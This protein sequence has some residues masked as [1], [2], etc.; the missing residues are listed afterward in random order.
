MGRDLCHASR[1]GQNAGSTI[2][3]EAGGKPMRNP[4][5]ALVAL[6]LVAAA[7]VPDAHAPAFDVASVKPKVDPGMTPMICLV[8]CSPGERLTVEGAR[9]DIRYMSL[10][11]LLLTA[12][13]LKPYQLSGPDW[14][15][16]Q[17]FDILAKIPEGGSKDKVPEMLQSLLAE[18][19]KLAVHRENK[20]Q[21]VYAL[22]VG[23]NGQ[24]L[25]A[26]AADADAPLPNTPGARGLYT[27]GGEASVDAN[28]NVAI[29]GGALG[30]MRGGRGS[31]GGMKMD[32]LKIT[33]S[34]LADLLT[35][36]EDRP[37]VDM[38][39]L[40]GAYRFTFVIVA[41]SG[42]SGR[43]G[44]PPADG[45]GGRDGG[46][47]PPRDI[48]GDALFQAL[49]RAGLKLEKSKAPVATIVVDHLEKT[50][51]EN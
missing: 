1:S 18:R 26:P 38:T 47:D 22:V 45:A 27:P 46:A 15:K 7:Q 49:E 5:I 37:V 9:V 13:R 44:G 51:T 34:G 4:F 32:M 25:Q 35:P 14:M 31:D 30:P 50:P 10:S 21:P 40:K 42:E 8:P 33:M 6:R 23:K 19:F 12:Y 16:T 39:S 20:E 36:H 2:N 11:R 48:F 17:R 28:G 29:T 43:K 3:L 41:P 24:K